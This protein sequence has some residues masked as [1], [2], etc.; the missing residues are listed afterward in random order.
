[1][2]R[3][4]SWVDELQ[5]VFEVRACPSCGMWITSPR[6]VRGDISLVYPD[7]YV[8]YRTERHAPVLSTPQAYRGTILD[9]GC[10]TGKYLEF[11]RKQGWSGTG[12][13]LSA[14]AARVAAARGFDV[15]VG[16]ALLVDL[17]LNAFDRVHCAHVLEHV[18]DPL[19][20]LRR[21]RGVVKESGVVEVTVPNRNSLGCILFRSYWHGLEL[22]RHL[23]HF[24]QSDIYALAERADLEVISVRHIAT[25]SPLLWSIDRLLIGLGLRR[26]A[27]WL[28]DRRRARQ[29]AYSLTG[30]AA[31]LRFADVVEYVLKP[32]R[33]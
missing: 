10:G 5:G 1:V 26:G 3:S 17:P 2:R 31:L 4:R 14:A 7:S 33:G 16:D 12:V 9:I 30:L 29:T 27:P 18:H 13:E 22:P 19:Q 15:T 11:A 20:L 8:P 32:M 25:P 21:M 6:P 28:R 24:R 23:F